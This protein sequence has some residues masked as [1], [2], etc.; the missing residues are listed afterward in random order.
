MD[1]DLSALHLLRPAWLLVSLTGA[2]LWLAW[3]MQRR[4]RDAH[5]AIDAALLPYLRVDGPAS[6]GM[7]PIDAAAL[8][9]IVGGVAAAGPAWQRDAPDFQEN[10]APLVAAVDL[11]PSMAATD[12]APSRLE[13]V[14]HKL[15][16]LV[17]ERRGARTGLVAYAGTAHLVLPPTDDSD[18]LNVFI[19]ALAPGMIAAPGR[20]VDG[21]VALAASL[22]G[23]AA[24][25]GTVLL[26]T[27]GAGPVRRNAAGPQ[28][29]VLAVGQQNVG[30]VLDGAGRPRLDARG[31]PVADD[32]DAA[33]LKTMA[34]ALDAPLGSLAGDASDLRWIRLHAQQ[35]FA[36][37]QDSGAAQWKDAGYWLCLPLALL[38][39]ACV[40]RGYTVAWSVTGAVLLLACAGGL[41]TPVRAG[42][43][44]DA[45]L[46]PDQQ[47]RIAYDRGAYGEAA[48][49]FQDPYWKGR[50]A[51]AAGDYANAL[52]AF[53]RLRTAEGYFYQGNTQVR[54]HHY[55][56]ARAAYRE[57]LRLRPE[58]A[59]ARFNLSIV[60]GLID[61]MQQEDTQQGAEPPDQTIADAAAAKGK[62]IAA[63]GAGAPSEAD[64]LRNLSVSPAQ[65]LRDKFAIEAAHRGS[66]PA[67]ATP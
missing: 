60:D 46:T 4:A 51:Y 56:A 45:F 35:H 50:A 38:A 9:L 26:L 49:H 24:R 7:R 53:A 66:A 27:D 22:F 11:S 10:R 17:A 2:L 14:Q 13:A 61:A 52:A 64:W 54:L 25:A 16:D 33:A 20:D 12:V 58:W 29:L 65:F 59:P 19:D 42:P 40:R 36:S 67:G 28:V 15:R 18:M 44:A 1:L 41:P 5:A 34:Q 3:R 8:L 37:V 32:F 57:A 39:L 62:P 23:D 21:V 48:A 63:A 31:N 6:R 30:A 43:L 47:G 55:D